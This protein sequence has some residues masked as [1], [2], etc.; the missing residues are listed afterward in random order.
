MKG[1]KRYEIKDQPGQVGR[2]SDNKMKM[3]RNT[4]AQHTF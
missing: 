4:E 1:N 3:K 2:A